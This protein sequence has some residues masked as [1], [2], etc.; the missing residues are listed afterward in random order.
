MGCGCMKRKPVAK[1]YNF[2]CL[3]CGRKF[4]INT[5]GAIGKMGAQYV[6]RGVSKVVIKHCS[7]NIK[8]L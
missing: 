1:D 7:T 2:L 5:S 3:D 4:K 6:I 8:K